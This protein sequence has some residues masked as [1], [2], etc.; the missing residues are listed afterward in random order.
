MPRFSLLRGI[1]AVAIVFPHAA[2]ACAPDPNPSI[3]LAHYICGAEDGDATPNPA[4]LRRCGA[5]LS[6]V[7][8][9]FPDGYAGFEAWEACNAPLASILHRQARQPGPLL[10]E[11]H[12][13]TAASA[14]AA[15]SRGQALIS[16]TLA[17][18]IP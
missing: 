17:R 10:R 8:R 13:A 18:R 16:D 12:V 5:V 1:V 14:P 7:T 11:V 15:P 6:A 9:A 4:E 2:F 3:V